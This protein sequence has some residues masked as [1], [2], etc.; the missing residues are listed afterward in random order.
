MLFAVHVSSSEW[1]HKA[2]QYMLDWME[3]LSQVTAPKDVVGINTIV[4][5][6]MP[7]MY[8]TPPWMV[9]VGGTP[10][11]GIQGKLRTCLRG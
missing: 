4:V 5:L 9:C 10:I 3:V 8:S 1:L 7:L 11:C 6:P 2:R